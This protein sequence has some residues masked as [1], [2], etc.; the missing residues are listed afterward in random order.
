MS[1]VLDNIIW[2]TLVGPHARYAAGSNGA[3][4]YA[5]GFSPIVGFANAQRPDFDAL[6][7]ICDPGEHFYCSG[8]DG[9]A[10]AGWQIEADS[11]MCLMVYAASAS[12]PLPEPI[13]AASQLGPEHAAQAVDLAALTLPGPFGLRTIELGDYFGVFEGER[14]VAMAGERMQAGAYHEISGVCT[15]PDYQG[16]GLA[17]QLMLIVMNLQRAREETPFLHVMSDN[18]SARRLYERMG[19]SNYLEPVVRVI[20]PVAWTRASRNPS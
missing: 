6:T 5:R 15:H 9:P 11:T 1:H 10:P 19:F 16:R 8:W 14:L 20:S 17:R 12:G 18:T 3:R 13:G 2:N 7:P 4:R